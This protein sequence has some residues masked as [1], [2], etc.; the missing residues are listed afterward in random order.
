L[1]TLLYAISLHGGESSVTL[2]KVP[3]TLISTLNDLASIFKD[4][5]FVNQILQA[6]QRLYSGVQGGQILEKEDI[7]A[8]LEETKTL[9]QQ[10]VQTMNSNQAALIE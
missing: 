10:L 7:S 5:F 8:I 3:T 9:L 2:S 4:Q 1:K 6:K